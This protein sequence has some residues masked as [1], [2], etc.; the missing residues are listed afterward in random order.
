MEAYEVVAYSTGH[1]RCDF[2]GSGK[3][4]LKIS[5][6]GKIRQRKILA[7]HTFFAFPPRK[8]RLRFRCRI[9]RCDF[10]KLS[11]LF[12]GGAAEFSAA[13]S[14]CSTAIPQRFFCR[15]AAENFR[16]QWNPFIS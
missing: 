15:I 12:R 2:F 6:S 9:F 13:E 7:V 1:T 10:R 16:S 11:I 5:R 3:F 4:V 14:F 8:I